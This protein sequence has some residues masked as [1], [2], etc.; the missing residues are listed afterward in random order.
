MEILRNNVFVRLEM[1][2]IGATI[3]DNGLSIPV[4][5][6]EGLYTRILNK[7]RI[8]VNQTGEA[9]SI[10][11]A[12]AAADGVG[13]VRAMMKVAASPKVYVL[14]YHVAWDKQ[15]ELIEFIN[16][17]LMK[18]MVPSQLM[19]ETVIRDIDNRILY[20]FSVYFRFRTSLEFDMD[21]ARNGL[22]NML[23]R[24]IQRGAFNGMP[25]GGL[26]F[27]LTDENRPGS[28]WATTGTYET[29]QLPSDVS[30]YLGHGG[31]LFSPFSSTYN[32]RPRTT[33][34]AGTQFKNYK[35][36]LKWLDLQTTKDRRDG[37]VLKAILGMILLEETRFS[38]MY[39][40]LHRVSRSLALLGPFE[41]AE[42]RTVLPATRLEVEIRGGMVSSLSLID[43][44]RVTFGIQELSV[45]KMWIAMQHWGQD[46][47]NAW[48]LV[49]HFYG[50]SPIYS[51]SDRYRMMQAAMTIDL[52]FNSA[53][54]DD[55]VL[56]SPARDYFIPPSTELV[57]DHY[58][59]QI[60]Y[61]ERMIKETPEQYGYAEEF[62]YG[63]KEII[64]A[65]GDPL[66]VYEFRLAPDDG[67]VT[68]FTAA[69]LMEITHSGS[70]TRTMDRIRMDGG[71][72][73]IKHPVN[74]DM[75]E[76]RVRPDLSSSDSPLVPYDGQG[77]YPIGSVKF[78]Y[79]FEDN[80]L[81]FSDN[82]AFNRRQY[83]Y[84]IKHTPHILLDE[85]IIR[86]WVRQLPTLREGFK[87]FD[88]FEFVLRGPTE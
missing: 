81:R 8:S 46:M 21:R 40:G 14:T 56:A 5:R 74:I 82:A 44:K 78:P 20:Y 72:V 68:T 35:H 32:N 59:N 70:F 9:G 79:A 84:A 24:A 7:L 71:V 29:R 1:A 6:G 80:H 19:D 62:F 34:V 87:I 50:S 47:A 38:D 45:A 60:K 48:W 57:D 58:A 69:Q 42:P 3:M 2:K 4:D 31:L 33:T 55:A 18:L 76:T 37:D 52:G 13:F 17:I 77:E 15:P 86:N 27:L 88:E 49:D 22:E 39:A 26:N 66:S 23:S 16:L 43:W 65:P 25:A 61:I 51:R 36:F 30:A 28:G 54:F 75:L 63:S 41:P 53:I 85:S 12:L 73:C 64:R 67:P 83:Q 10:P 11:S